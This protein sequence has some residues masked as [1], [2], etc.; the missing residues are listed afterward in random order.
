M[1][2][3]NFFHAVHAVAIPG[4]RSTNRQYHSNH[5]SP[6]CAPSK[7]DQYQSVHG[8][9]F[10]EINRVGEQGNTEPMAR[11]IPNSTAK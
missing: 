10:E 3:L 8:G 9:I 11:A 5:G 7:G 6:P 1:G 4:A 2:R